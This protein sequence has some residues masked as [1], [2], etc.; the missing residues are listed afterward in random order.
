[1]KTTIREIDHCFEF[2]TPVGFV[3]ANALL[4]FEIKEE[5]ATYR[6]P[7]SDLGCPASCEV[8]LIGLV[9][10]SICLLS[11]GTDNVVELTDHLTFGPLFH[12]VA[13]TIEE[14]TDPVE[15][16]SIYDWKAN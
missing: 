16:T 15:F 6:Y 11:N 8:S 3:Q 14:T 9:V 4:E 7:N 5:K 10:D 13:K 2:E 12:W 1:M